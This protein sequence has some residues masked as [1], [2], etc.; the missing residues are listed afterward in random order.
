VLDDLVPSAACWILHAG[1]KSKNNDVGYPEQGFDIGEDLAF[2][3]LGIYTVDQ[4]DLTG[5]DGSSGR[6]GLRL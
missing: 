5:K 4:E 6:G 1:F 2:G 3:A